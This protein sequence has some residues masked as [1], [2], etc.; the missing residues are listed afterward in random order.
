MTLILLIDLDNT[1]LDNDMEVFIPTYLKSLGEYLANHISPERLIPALLEATQSMLQNNR[2]DRTLKQVFD[3]EFYEPLGLDQSTMAAPIKEFYEKVFPALRSLT[4]PR[5]AA[6]ELVREATDRGYDLVLATNPLFPR[7]A[8]MQ[9]L[10]WTGISL[11]ETSFKLIPS[12]ETFHFAKPNP[13]FF[14]EILGQLGW[15]QKPVLMV[16]DDPYND[17]IPAASIGIQTFWVSDQPPPKKEASFNPSGWGGLEDIL[18]WVDQR[19]ISECMPDFTSLQA[20]LAILRSTPAVLINMS[21]VLPDTLWVESPEPGAWSF[22]EIICHLR[23]VDHDVNLLRI[24]KIL[25]EENPF[26]PGIDTDQWAVERQ[27]YCQNGRQALQEFVETRI[28]LLGIL[29]NLKPEDWLR[30]ARHAIFGPT[31][32]KELVNI[33]ASHDRLHIRQAMETLEKVSTVIGR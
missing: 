1:L 7:T 31:H 10:S 18:Q 12:Y 8:I 28:E 15:P 23:D 11:D 33:I 27:Y 29:D 13:A 24:K 21:Q 19:S 16:G 22:T 2:P 32:I 26:L 9:R 20:M 4:K 14:T 30:T 17:I 6:I 3:A 25:T 5:P